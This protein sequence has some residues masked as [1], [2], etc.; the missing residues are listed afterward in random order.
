MSDTS[1]YDSKPNILRSPELIKVFVGYY[2]RSTR[3]FKSLQP[4]KVKNNFK[5]RYITQQTERACNNAGNGK[6]AIALK[7]YYI[8]D[9]KINDYRYSFII[10]SSPW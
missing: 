8:K 1:F 10:K 2:S 9:L 5:L 3:F 4:T 7:N 6:L